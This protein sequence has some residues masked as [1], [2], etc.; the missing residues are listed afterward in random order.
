MDTPESLRF[1]VFRYA[2]GRPVALRYAMPHH[3][4]CQYFTQNFNV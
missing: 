1:I 2:I 3:N 4:A